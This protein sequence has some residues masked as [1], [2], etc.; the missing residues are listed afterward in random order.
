MAIYLSLYRHLSV[1]YCRSVYPQ[2]CSVFICS[3][4]VHRM[5]IVFLYIVHSL[6]QDVTLVPTLVYEKCFRLCCI[7]IQSSG[8]QWLEYSCTECYLGEEWR[9]AGTWYPVVW[10][11]N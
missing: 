3:L 9:W 6:W 4:H 2:Q 10:Q 11:K 7:I 5:F 1:D 8:A